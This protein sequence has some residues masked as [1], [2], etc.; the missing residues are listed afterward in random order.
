M[1]HN[2]ERL[3]RGQGGRAAGAQGGELGVAV[4]L[5]PAD[6]AHDTLVGTREGDVI[7]T[8]AMRLQP[9]KTLVLHHLKHVSCMNMMGST[10]LELESISIL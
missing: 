6:V 7:A 9:S 8:R 10:V 3:M 4:L 2:I 1:V 5:P